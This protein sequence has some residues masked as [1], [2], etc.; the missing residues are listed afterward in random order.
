MQLL[1]QMQAINLPQDKE[2]N[3]WIED[4]ASKYPKEDLISNLSSW[5]YTRELDDFDSFHIFFTCPQPEYSI[6]NFSFGSSE[7]YIMAHPYFKKYLL[8]K[9]NAIFVYCQVKPCL[10]DE[11]EF[12]FMECFIKVAKLQLENPAEDLLTDYLNLALALGVLEGNEKVVVLV[13]E[14]KKNVTFD[15]SAA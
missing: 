14:M 12:I 15:L 1:F 7:N 6:E 9:I 3:P 5:T 8:E 13:S 2:N 4:L 11:E 10:N